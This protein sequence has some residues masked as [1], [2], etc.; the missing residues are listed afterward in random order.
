MTAYSEVSGPTDDSDSS[1][2]S[3]QLTNSD[4]SGDADDKLSIIISVSI[5]SPIADNPTSTAKFSVRVS[6]AQAALYVYLSDLGKLKI[7]PCSSFGSVK[8]LHELAN[9]FH[10]MINPAYLSSEMAKANKGKAE[11][12]Q[13]SQEDFVAKTINTVAESSFSFAVSL[14]GDEVKGSVLIGE[15]KAC[16]SFYQQLKLASVG[17]YQKL[18][19]GLGSTQ[20]LNLI[21][22]FTGEINGYFTSKRS[23]QKLLFENYAVEMEH[24]LFSPFNSSVIAAIDKRKCVFDESHVVLTVDIGVAAGGMPA[25]EDFK[26]KV[27]NDKANLMDHSV[28]KPNGK[29]FMVVKAVTIKGHVIKCDVKYPMPGQDRVSPLFDA[30]TMVFRAGFVSVRLVAGKYQVEIPVTED[31]TLSAAKSEQG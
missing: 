23:V 7:I 16:L 29:R 3:E 18:V 19:G 21:D 11:D 22:S 10:A 31:L 28:V 1:D 30:G 12:D 25:T 26:L 14:T 24:A 8:Q 2:D 15:V 17:F 27:A 9:F 13:Q 4:Q 6:P 5:P 20:I